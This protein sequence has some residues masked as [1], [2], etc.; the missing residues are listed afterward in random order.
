[1]YE[2]KREA[3]TSAMLRVVVH[4]DGPCRTGRR[5][6]LTEYVRN[7]K[8]VPAVIRPPT[9][10]MHPGSGIVCLFP[11]PTDKSSP[12]EPNKNVTLE[13]CVP[14]RTMTAMLRIRLTNTPCVE[15]RYRLYEYG[16]HLTFIQRRYETSAPN[17][18]MRPFS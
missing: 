5:P 10:A 11:I 12:E 15:A 18:T 17:V 1:M 6:R 16:Q 14:C 9:A 3:A 7:I 2:Q 4:P 8:L 13:T